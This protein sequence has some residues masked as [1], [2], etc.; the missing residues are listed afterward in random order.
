MPSST[1]QRS[2]AS[3]VLLLSSGALAQTYPAKPLRVIVP[4]PA[5]GAID[6]QARVIGQK[7]NERLGQPV[8]VD[9]RPGAATLVGTEFAA[10]AAADG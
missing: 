8:I 1:L 6:L 10:R 4:F 9:N 7:L 2:L 3:A 5:G